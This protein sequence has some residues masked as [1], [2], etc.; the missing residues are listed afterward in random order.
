[1]T[2]FTA[3]T[4]ADLGGPQWLKDRRR[5]AFD[6]FRTASLPSAEEEIWRYSRI[7]ELDLDAYSPAP[8][9]DGHVPD[10]LR[11]VVEAIGAHAGLL[12]LRNGRVAAARL[13]PELEAKGVFIGA[14]GDE[15]VTSV[16]GPEDALVH[17][18]DAFLTDV[19]L[20]RIPD[21]VAVDRPI[22]VLSWI[23]AEK[24][25][26]FPH[27]V[28]QAGRQSEVTVVVHAGGDD[29]PA[30]SVPIV[31]LQAADGAN[32]RHLAVQDVGTQTWDVGQLR[33]SGER[34]STVRSWL[35]VL[36]GD[37]SRLFVDAQ[38]PGQGATAEINGVYFGDGSQVHDIRSV[39]R[40]VTARGT[41]DFTLKGAVVDEARGVYSGVIVVE[42][43]AKGTSAFLTNRN[44]VLSDGARV[45]SVP[46]LEIINENDL[47]S[48]GHA[49]ATGP[50]D[51][52]HLFYLESR[53]VPTEVA[54]RLIVL[55]FFGE[56][57]DEAPVPGLR[58]LLRQAVAVKLQG[59]D[60]G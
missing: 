2:A 6:R 18:H 16:E 37:Y 55:G 26:V 7:D 33:I 11:P 43:G 15:P 8:V 48:C 12:V 46:N 58:E 31:E 14:A 56:V 36:G 29:V 10:R 35:V 54:E 49:A 38:M 51:E 32:I 23:D 45:D 3:D 42:A 60:G 34:D 59:C 30:L 5:A 22:V 40:H 50:V 57:L 9:S 39:Q 41:S 27:V 13:H 25:A 4:A 17:L 19:A 20:V 44:L 53:G 1:V 21:G 52:E 28:V 47:R 24:A